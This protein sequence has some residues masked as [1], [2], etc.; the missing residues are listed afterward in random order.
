MMGFNSIWNSAII[1]ACGLL[2]SLKMSKLSESQMN[3]AG[4]VLQLAH[5]TPSAVSAGFN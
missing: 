3:P 4:A 5:H 1:K 2:L